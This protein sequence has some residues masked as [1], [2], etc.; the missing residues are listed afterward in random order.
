MRDILIDNTERFA[1]G[2]P[3]NNALLWGARGMGKSLAG[4]GRACQRQCATA[5]APTGS[6]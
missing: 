1:S 2:L 4:Q 3:A 6:S 5:G